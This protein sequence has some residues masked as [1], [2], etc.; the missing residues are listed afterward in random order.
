MIGSLTQTSRTGS[1][2]QLSHAHQQHPLG[3][4]NESLR[5]WVLL[6][7]FSYVGHFWMLSSNRPAMPIRVSRVIRCVRVIRVIRVI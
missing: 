1:M 4:G 5:P 6:P 7:T 3:N 2:R